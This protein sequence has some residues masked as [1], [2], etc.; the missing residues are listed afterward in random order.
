[1]LAR[2]ERSP[3]AVFY[4]REILERFPA[5]FDSAKHEGLLK[6]APG[7]ASYSHGLSQPRSLLV[8][9]DGTFEAYDEEDVEVDPILLTTTDVRRWR[10]D[11]G[12]LALG[13]QEV[14][15]LAGVPQPLDDRLYFL[16]DRKID[17]QAVACVLGLLPNDQLALERL[18][19]LP[20]LLSNRY[21]RFIVLC[22]TFVPAP[23]ADRELTSFHVFASPL[24]QDG[25]S[26]I[27]FQAMLHSRPSQRGPRIV[28]ND[29]EESEFETEGF[30]SRL[31]IEVTGTTDPRTRNVIYVD[32]RKATLGD[33]TFRG[34]VRLVVALFQT[35]SGFVTREEL[36]KEHATD[37]TPGVMPVGFDQAVTRLRK[38]LDHDGGEDSLIERFD[39]CLRLST[40][41]RYVSYDR[42]RLLE[43][44]DDLVR[45][46]AALLPIESTTSVAPVPA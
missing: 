42:Q 4:E 35:E 16:G 7:G 39:N 43:H 41:H 37:G 17:G 24:W 5:E 28:L 20:N 3:A 32:G 33:V 9:E 19:G 31:P 22:P 38:P 45:E 44:R 2:L 1:M 25:T 26:S 6:L 30:S 12:S 34:F 18:R 36:T 23:S 21:D 40:H 13:V 27:D 8:R 10:L 15:Q 11:L 46:M 14:N 29:E